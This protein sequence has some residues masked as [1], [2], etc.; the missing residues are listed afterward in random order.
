MV[1]VGMVSCDIFGDELMCKSVDVG[2][3]MCF[4]WQVDC[5]LFFV[6]VVLKQL[7]YYFFIGENSV[8]FVFDLVDLLVGVF[9]VVEIVYVGLFGVVCELFVVCL[10][11]FV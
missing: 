10:I 9:D 5:V 6:M 11:E 3:D 2:F 7:F 8:D 1:F 4:I